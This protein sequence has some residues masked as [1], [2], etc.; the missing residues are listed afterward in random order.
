[1]KFKTAT[2]A[3]LETENPEVIQQMEKYYPPAEATE[4]KVKNTPKKKTV[5]EE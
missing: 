2:G 5:D 1:M 4:D 3:I